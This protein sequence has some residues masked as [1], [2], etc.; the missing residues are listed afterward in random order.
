MATWKKII[1][2]EILTKP[3]Q[4]QEMFLSLPQGQAELSEGFHPGWAAQLVGAS[5]SAT[6][7]GSIPLRAHI[8]ID[9]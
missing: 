7:A 6:A 4:P 3:N 8:R 9:Q 2:L 1:K 5:S